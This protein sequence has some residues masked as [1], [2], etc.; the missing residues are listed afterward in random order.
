MQT[1]PHLVSGI[2]PDGNRNYLITYDHGYRSVED[3]LARSR[4]AENGTWGRD[5]ELCIL[6]HLLDTPVY[7]FQGGVENY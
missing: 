5:F 3:Y 4:M 1:I 7:S 2:G 6:A